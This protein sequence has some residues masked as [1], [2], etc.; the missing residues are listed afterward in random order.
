MNDLTIIY[1]TNNKLK[2]IFFTNIKNHLDELVKNKIPII[3]VSQKPIDLGI[4]ICVGEIG[5]SIY[6]IYKQILIGSQ[7]AKTEFIACCED[8]CLYNLEHFEHRP[9]PDTFSYNINRWWVEQCGKFRWRNR[10]SMFACIVSR[11]L[12]I[13]T[14]EEKFNMFPTD[15]KI[16]FFGEPGRFE[17]KLNLPHIKYE[18]SDICK[19]P[20]LTFNHR[21][22]LGGMRQWRKDR[23][24]FET[25]L[26]P[27]GNAKELWRKMHV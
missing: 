21:D 4:N 14:L 1:Y 11:K 10:A 15:T 3:S 7:K 23:D 19:T 20:I 18:R 22:S 16:K 8:D 9:A 24:K 12:I 5:S 27:W 2:D 26:E 13:E 17:H 6:N 25:D